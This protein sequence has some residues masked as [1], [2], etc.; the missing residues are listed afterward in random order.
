MTSF[1]G[2]FPFPDR[3]RVLF[4]W[5]V[6]LSLTITH[7]ADDIGVY[8]SFVVRVILEPPRWARWFGAEAIAAKQLAAGERAR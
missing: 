4:G 7:T 6:A 1:S 8:D 5:S 2:P 3:C